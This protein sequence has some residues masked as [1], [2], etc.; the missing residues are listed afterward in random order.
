MRVTLSR[1]GG[2]A[3]LPGLARPVTLDSSSLSQAE[4][5]TLELLLRESRFTNLPSQLGSPTPGAADYR[6]YE[7][8]LD[9]QTSRHTVRVVEPIDDPVLQRLVGFLEQHGKANRPT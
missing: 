2:L 4:Q 8:T 9:D 6:T 5:A 7:I 3:Y 1:S